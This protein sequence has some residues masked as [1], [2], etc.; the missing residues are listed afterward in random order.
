MTDQQVQARAMAANN[1]GVYFAQTEND[2]ANGG[3][4]SIVEI[5]GRS[6]QLTPTL[7]P[8]TQSGYPIKANE[9]LGIFPNPNIS[10]PP[11]N[12]IQAQT[13]LE[14]PGTIDQGINIRPET[15][16]QTTGFRPEQ[17]E[18]DRASMEIVNTDMSDYDKKMVISENQLKAS[19][20]LE[21]LNERLA[22]GSG[23]EQKAAKSRLHS[24]KKRYDGKA[25]E[26]AK[27]R[28]FMSRNINNGIG[29]LINTIAE[30]SG[31]SFEEAM[32]DELFIGVAKP[33]RKKK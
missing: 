13:A 14:M 30:G 28:D 24:L 12:S 17:N 23:W 1:P 8:A 31:P 15:Y 33:K 4:G 32:H 26:K 5:D 7:L 18:A 19:Y 22:N 25:Y 11:G 9:G 3:L 10:L 16:N 6:G 21:Y 27:T 29:G 2:T 20:D